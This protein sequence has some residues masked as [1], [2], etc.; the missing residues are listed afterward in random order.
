MLKHTSAEMNESTGHVQIPAGM[1]I[2]ETCKRVVRLHYFPPFEWRC[3]T[4][5]T[6]E[7]KRVMVQ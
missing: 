7:Y 5:R 2:E 6:A 1:Y 4:R 3:L